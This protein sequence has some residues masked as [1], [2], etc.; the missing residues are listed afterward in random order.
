[1]PDSL[2]WPANHHAGM[3]GPVLK[4]CT[5]TV[6][7]GLETCALTLNY[8]IG[9]WRLTRS[10]ILIEIDAPCELAIGFLRYQI[11]HYPRRML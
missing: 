9:D 8:P 10:S 11:Q 3:Y 2:S 7:G 6:V 1:M 4:S 5:V